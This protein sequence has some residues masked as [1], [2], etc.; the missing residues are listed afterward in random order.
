MQIKDQPG[1][2]LGVTVEDFDHTTASEADIQTLKR[3][4]YTKKIAVLK[5]QDLTPAQFL[6]LG[7]RLGRPET[8]YEPMYR[9]PDVPEV[10]V[11]SNTPEDGRQIGV[12]KTGK[13]W[14]ADYQFMPDP[15]G[16]TLI[17]PQVIPEKNRGTYFIDMGRA[18]ERLSE[19]LRAAV[20][21][22]RCRHSVRKYF[23]IRP[24]D[25]Y[26]PLSEI[27][28]E[29]ETRTPPVL[30]PTAFTH[31]MTGETVL[32]VSEGFT[33]GIESQ[34]GEPLEDKLLDRL[35]EATGQLDDTFA[36]EGIHLQSFEQGDLLVWDN[37]SLVHRARH[38]T[39][40]EPTVSYRVTVHDERA[41]YD[42]MRAA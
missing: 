33:V 40:P 11:S 10:F 14:H 4:V 29:V 41:L 35:F 8:Y 38:T 20:R 9:H 1:A 6:A 22:T 31:P 27:I 21:G 36:H 28:E 18:Y 24:Q 26:R 30:R 7:R 15:F 2:A 42:G 37:R 12:P 39:T 19:E 5:G 34:D 17:H 13:F 16:L 3:T 32:Y 23:K 25:V